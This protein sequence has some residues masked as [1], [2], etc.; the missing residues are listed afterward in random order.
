[1]PCRMDCL[2]CRVRRLITQIAEIFILALAGIVIGTIVSLFEVLFVK[3]L[4]QVTWFHQN[5]G[6]CLWLFTLPTVGMLI[7]WMFERF[8][9]KARQGIG[10]VFK[11]NQGTEKAL[12][13]RIV[14]MMMISTWLSHLAGASVGK[15]GVGMQIGAVVSNTISRQLPYFRERKT[16]FLITGM[17]AGFSGLFGTPFTAVFFAMEVL[18]SGVIEYRALAPALAASLSAAGIARLCGLGKEAFLLPYSFEIGLVHD[19]WKLAILGILFGL[20]GGFFAWCM[21]QAHH[22]F[23]HSRLNPYYRIVFF[24]AG[25]AGL[26]WLFYDGRYSGSGVNLITYACTG[27]QIYPWDF[28]LKFGLSVLSLSMGFIGGEVTPLFAIGASL[29][30]ILGPLF[31]YPP[32]FGAALGYAAVFG[33][34]TNT[35]LA[36]MMVGMEIFGMNFFPFFFVCCSAAYLANGNLSIYSLQRRLDVVFKP[37]EY[38]NS[39]NAANRAVDNRGMDKEKQ[40]GQAS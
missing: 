28:A 38:P 39:I 12:P 21:H 6:N 2:S 10:L 30:A 24:S 9:T 36:A 7:V 37:I 33:A 16:I 27:N 34:G 19:C 14:F 15:E 1:M 26:L 3:V 40:A 35:W 25:L 23:D 31:G 5:Y 8:G 17:A 11:V 13:K 29:G 4:N 32:A 20:V 22:Y 18:V